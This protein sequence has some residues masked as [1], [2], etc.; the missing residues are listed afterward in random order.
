MSPS[1]PVSYQNNADMMPTKNDGPNK[2][3][4]RLISMCYL[5]GILI[6]HVDY[7]AALDLAL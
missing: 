6:I 5:G 2:M 1:Y 7:R 3:N 4:R